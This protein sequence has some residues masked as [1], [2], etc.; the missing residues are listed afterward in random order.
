MINFKTAESSRDDRE[1]FVQKENEGYAWTG[2]GNLT[3]NQRKTCELTVAGPHVM[4]S[5]LFFAGFI[6]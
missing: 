2:F 1:F 6:D 3:H 4:I 5:T